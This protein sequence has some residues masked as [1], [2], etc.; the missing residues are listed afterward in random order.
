MKKFFVSLLFVFAGGLIWWALARTAQF[1]IK[2]WD[3]KFETVLRHGLTDLGLTN[4]DIVSSVHQIHQD[5]EGEW[6]AHRMTIKALDVKKKEALKR[7]FEESGAKVEE[8]DGEASS[9]LIRRGSRIYQEIQ[10]VKP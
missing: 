4:Q 2:K 10:F 9:L 3:A 8:R 7:F 1:S 5:K 6:V